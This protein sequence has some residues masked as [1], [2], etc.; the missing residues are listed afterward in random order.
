VYYMLIAWIC[1]IPKEENKSVSG[2]WTALTTISQL[3]H[4]EIKRTSQGFLHLS[5]EGSWTSKIVTFTWWRVLVIFVL[6]INNPLQFKIVY[7]IFL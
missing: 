1:V 6:Q 5:S 2:T 7:K 4:T 3:R